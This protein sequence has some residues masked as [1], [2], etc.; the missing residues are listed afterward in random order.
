VIDRLRACALTALFAILAV[1]ASGGKEASA[2]EPTK[3]IELISHATET[4]STYQVGMAIV[5]AIDELK[6]LPHGAKVIVVRGAGG[7]KAR[8]YVAK[9]H[10]D[11]PNVMQILT[12]SQINNPIL[13][14]SE[15]NRSSFRGVAIV[16]DEPLLLVVNAQSPYNSIKDIVEAA[17]ANPGKVLQ[18]GGDFGQVSSLVGKMF[19]DS[20]GVKITY[21]PFDDEGVLQLAGGHVDFLLENPSQIRKFVDAGRMRILGAPNKLSF[22]PDV[23]TF[24]EAGFKFQTLRQYRGIWM[25]KDTPDDVVAFY[26]EMLRKVV[27]APSYKAFLEANSLEPVWME[28]KEMEDLMDSD[29]ALY[30][31]LDE[32]LN[33]IKPASQQ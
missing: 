9:D 5:R 7:N 27:E 30:R 15:V 21:T 10:A 26:R 32:E 33:L 25:A 16:A 24:E 29:A 22:A 23:P 19:A 2:F 17:R 6:L 20:Q 28:G 31:K 12:P 14:Q 13:S 3:Q 1:A 18:G 8:Q 11:D 4:S